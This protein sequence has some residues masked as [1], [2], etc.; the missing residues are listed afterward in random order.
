MTKE[1]KSHHPLE[2]GSRVTAY[3]FDP[4]ELILLTDSKDPLYDKRV[5]DPVGREYILNIA[6]LGVETPILVRNRGGQS[7]VTKGKQRT[8]AALTLN[9]LTAGVKYTGDIKAVHVAIKE[10]GADTEFVKLL[11]RFT[12]GRALKIKAVPNNSG[13]DQRVRLAM[14]AEN[15]HR[16]GSELADTIS[17]AREE[18]EKY[19]TSLDDIARAEGVSVATV[20]RWTKDTKE[21]KPPKK[22]GKATRPSAKQVA[23]LA[24]RISAQ[25][26]PRERALLHWILGTSNGVD[27]A[28][29]FLGTAHSSTAEARA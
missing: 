21:T 29:M 26:T 4:Q 6:D 25:A 15:A 3:T 19:G 1:R 14:R 20:K 12:K 17:W 11:T 9:A 13:D 28:E 22:R 27:V 2:G 8:K 16:R 10:F 18:H 5:H 24:D 23:E 7:I